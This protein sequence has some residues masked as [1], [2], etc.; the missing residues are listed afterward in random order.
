VTWSVCTL[1]RKDRI[2]CTIY[3]IFV[4]TA[5]PTE[6]CDNP[7]VYHKAELYVYANA[8]SQRCY[9]SFPLPI[10]DSRSAPRK[11]GEHSLKKILCWD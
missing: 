7:T 4:S 3:C 5:R 8:C 11:T 2:N 10:I 9:V 6:I 1:M